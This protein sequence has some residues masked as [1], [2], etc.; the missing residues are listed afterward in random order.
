M[1]KIV[2][3]KEYDTHANWKTP[4][5]IY[6]P[7]NDEFDFDFDPCPLDAEFD[8][9]T[10]PWGDRNFVNPPYQWRLKEKFVRKAYDESLK[11]KLSVILLPVSTATKIFHEVILPNAE[12][13]FIRRRVKF[14]GEDNKGNIIDNITAPFDSML[15]I[16]RPV[17]GEHKD[18]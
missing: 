8:G 15:V 5:Y 4:S 6:D 13:R 14:V 17:A 9:L 16:F 3:K 18:G 10:M 2:H 12:V 7:L 11:G 1:R